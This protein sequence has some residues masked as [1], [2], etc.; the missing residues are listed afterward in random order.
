MS[1]EGD[2]FVGSDIYGVIESQL[3]NISP[4]VEEIPTNE[5]LN[6]PVNDL[7]ERL[8]ERFTMTVPTLDL[9]SVYPSQTEGVVEVPGRF[10]DYGGS[11]ESTRVMGTVVT[12]H[13]PFSG[14]DIFFHLR[15]STSDSMPPRGELGDGEVMVTVRG[16]N[17]S[18]EGVRKELDGV[19]DTIVKYLNWQRGPV[20]AYN[21]SLPRLIRGAVEARRTKLLADRN[22]VANLGY[23]LKKRPDA[24][25]TYSV[26]VVRKKIKSTVPRPATTQSFEPEPALDEANYQEILT[27]MDNMALVMERSPTA[28]RR[29]GEE[30]IRWLFLIPLNGQYEGTATG[31][32]FNYG[33]KTDILIR[34]KGRNV[35]IA[36]CKFW[37]GPKAFLDTI[38]QLLGYLSWRDTKTA[39]VIFN[40]NRDFSKVLQSIRETAEQHPNKKSG[41]IKKSETRFRYMF[42]NPEDA[43]RELVL[44]V[45]AFN[46][47]VPLA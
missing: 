12:L 26:S 20:N 15:P 23:P 6:R 1:G 45:M 46:V 18:S 21:N 5:I 4:Q 36:E 29:M 31:E 42:S 16:H 37:D 9:G 39:V 10:A 32:T 30:D 8:V 3:A 13:I 41:P 34:D 28:F 43:D 38:N 47:P 14:Q 22:L 33:G 27:A 11:R 44:T 35:F 40:R 25:K 19:C 17:L 7:V 24:P 2:L